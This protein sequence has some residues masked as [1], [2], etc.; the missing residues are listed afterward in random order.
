MSLRA[1]REW[2]DLMISLSQSFDVEVDV[3]VKQKTRRFYWMLKLQLTDFHS[4]STTISVSDTTL[5]L[6]RRR[7][8]TNWIRKNIFKSMSDKCA[9]TSFSMQS[10]NCWG[11]C[12]FYTSLSVCVCVC[13]ITKSSVNKTSKNKWELCLKVFD[14]KVLYIILSTLHSLLGYKCKDLLE[15]FSSTIVLVFI[16]VL[17]SFL[18]LLF[19]NILYFTFIKPKSNKTSLN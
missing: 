19:E 10:R 2:N 6:S 17:S 16:K 12:F 4:F 5:K 9:E 1:S 7:L 3:V 14:V 15:I 18:D 8:I 11:V 13:V